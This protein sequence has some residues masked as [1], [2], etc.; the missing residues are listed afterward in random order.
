MD[1]CTEQVYQRRITELTRQLAERDATIVD[2]RAKVAD[3]SVR[4]AALTE[5][6]AQKL[7]EFLQASIQRYCQTNA[8]A[9]AA[10]RKAVHRR[11]ER[12]PTP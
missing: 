4:V 3:M 5:Q 12:P 11:P 7:L 8:T 2:L 9:P 1:V 10:G 6:V